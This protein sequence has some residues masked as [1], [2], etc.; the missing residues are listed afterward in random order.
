MLNTVVEKLLPGLKGHRIVVDIQIIYWAQQWKWKSYSEVEMWLYLCWQC[1]FSLHHKTE[2]HSSWLALWKHARL[3]HTHGNQRSPV[4]TVTFFIFVCVYET[5]FF[6][7]SFNLLEDLGRPS[8]IVMVR[9]F[10]PG[11]SWAMSPCPLW[12][13]TTR[14]PPP[15]QPSFFTLNSSLSGREVS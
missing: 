6:S 4:C 10:P 11:L 14:E 9:V 5:C 13:T 3:Q 1:D 15:P 8:P 12:N 7:I 2:E